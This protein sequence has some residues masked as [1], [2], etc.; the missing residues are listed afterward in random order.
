M[1]TSWQGT[2]KPTFLSWIRA[3]SQSLQNTKK[4]K[5]LKFS[6]NSTR[7]LGRRSSSQRQARSDLWELSPL[8]VRSKLPKEILLKSL[9]RRK[10][11]WRKAWKKSHQWKLGLFNQKNN[12]LWASKKLKSLSTRRTQLNFYKR[13]RRWLV[14]SHRYTLCRKKFRW[15]LNK[16][17]KPKN[18]R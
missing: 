14:K 6:K 9:S 10:S 4:L 12:P 3:R 16:W 13:K 17:T 7:G 8:T 5:T 1:G 18:L 15:D 2:R 11:L